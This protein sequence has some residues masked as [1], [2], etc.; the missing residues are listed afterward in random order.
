MEIEP[1][2]IEWG[3]FGS[4]ATVVDLAECLMHNWPAPMD[5]EAYITALMVCSAVLSRGED[6]APE[7]ARAAFIDAAREAGL[8]VANEDGFDWL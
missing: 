4:L 2:Q 5:G 3:D 6:D 8:S 1:V 7:H